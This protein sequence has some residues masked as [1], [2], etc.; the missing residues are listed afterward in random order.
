M[1]A[2]GADSPSAAEL[3]KPPPRRAATATAHAAGPLTSQ[4]VFAGARS[5]GRRP[6]STRP[7]ASLFAVT[8]LAAVLAAPGTASAAGPAPFPGTDLL[9]LAKKPKP[10]PK[11]KVPKAAVKRLQKMR[12][13]APYLVRVSRD[14]DEGEIKAARNFDFTLSGQ[15][16]HLKPPINWTMDPLGSASFR[17]RL[18]D[19]RW[20]D[21]LLY[22]YR[23]NGNRASL[24]KARRIA[25]DWIK[26][27]PRRA[28]T[29]DR[30]W[31][32]KVSGE[33]ASYLAYV[34]R[35]AACAKLARGKV[36]QTLL[37]SLLTHGKYLQSN[38]AHTVTNR[39]LFVDLGLLQLGKQVPF[40]KGAGKWQRQGE[41][42]FART[43][44]KL[45]VQGE[46]LWLEHS[47]TYHFLAE[48]VI[49]EY[50]KT[51]GIKQPEVAK[52]LPQM[53]ETA[54]WLIEP[55]NRWLQAG[56]SYQDDAGTEARLAAKEA[57]GLRFLGKSGMA[58]VRTGSTYLAVLSGFHSP[59]HKHSD[60]LSFD[61]YANGRRIVA[62]TGMYSKDPSPFLAFQQ[63][64]A[65]HS[66]LVVDG[67]E[68]SRAPSDA[69]GSGLRAAGQ[70][71]DWY[72]IEA[73]NPLLGPQGVDNSRIYLYKPGSA[74]I[75][76]DRV[77]SAQS[78]DYRRYL[79][80][81]HGLGLK[82]EGGILDLTDEGE[83][84]AKVSSESTDPN[85]ERRWIKG[86]ED[87]AGGL[88][89]PDFREKDGR[90]TAFFDT[91]G[92]VVDHAF[93]IALK[94]NNPL[95][96]EIDKPLGQ[97]P[98]RVPVERGGKPAF[99]LVVTRKDGRLSVDEEPV[100]PKG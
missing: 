51:P 7:L 92:T 47:T 77:R 61:L 27:N 81:G 80:F 95:K 1:P 11:P 84:V 79:Q 86:S 9:S 74:L 13:P 68:F 49:E 46:G 82:A 17:A 64:A 6:G 70:G 2:P 31:F 66:T 22:D 54:G 3:R 56:N 29:T 60:D 15:E 19:L 48:G 33:R 14:Y 36:A 16:V 4:P 52:I 38:A 85:E 97:D 45:T 53:K 43:V 75:V 34:T 65:A 100:K 24:K 35:A 18:H 20:L 76:L 58:F 78:H 41:K 8:L 62:D 28:P 99:T 21:L 69:Y 44:K 30:T 50:L 10:K 89:F 37:G 32:D 42:S 73:T 98:V 83:T 71:D 87:P 39:G 94:P 5:R 91:S 96:A 57:R 59:I 25:V 12:C 63:S 55:D 90:F 67:Q 40:L 26:H 23:H 88:I 93:T 72:A